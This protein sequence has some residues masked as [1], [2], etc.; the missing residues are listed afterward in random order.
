[1]QAEADQSAMGTPTK[2]TIKDVIERGYVPKIKRE[3]GGGY[4]TENQERE[5]G[6]DQIDHNQINM[7]ALIHTYAFK[8]YV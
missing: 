7:L 3:R 6:I 5:R 1:M 4:R 2:S 8:N